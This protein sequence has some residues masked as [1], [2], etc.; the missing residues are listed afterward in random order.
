MKPLCLCIWITN[1]HEHGLRQ[2]CG[3]LQVT[4]SVDGPGGCI[5]RVVVVVV[6]ADLV[7]YGPLVT[8]HVPGEVPLPPQYVHQ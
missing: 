2:V 7:L 1:F 3:Q 8:D 6:E 4:A 5:L